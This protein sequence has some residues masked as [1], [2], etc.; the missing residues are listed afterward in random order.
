LI[1]REQYYIDLLNPEYNICKIAGSNLG[2]KHSEITKEKLSIS[3]KGVKRGILY[4]KILSKA[5]R[6]IEHSTTLNIKINST[7]KLVT[8]T[9]ILKMSQRNAGIRVKVYDKNNILINEFPTIMS[10]AKYFGVSSS[11]IGN[12]FK[13]GI[14]YDDYIYKFEVKD[15][16][17]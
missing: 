8:T 13:T 17:I 10:A 6:G 2:F 9:T 11:T 12:I 3:K 14:S 16:R 5:T 4:S 7:P 1:Q 15:T